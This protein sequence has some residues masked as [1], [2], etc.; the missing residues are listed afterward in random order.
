[1][2]PS[3]KP[4]EM[5]SIRRALDGPPCGIAPVFRWLSIINVRAPTQWPRHQHDGFEVIVVE[6]GRYNYLLNDRPAL[7]KAGVI[8]VVKPGDWHEDRYT[9]PLQFVGVGFDLGRELPG[10]SAFSIFA[11]SVRPEQ[12][13]LPGSCAELGPLLARLRQESARPDAVTPYVQDALLQQFFWSLIRLFPREVLSPWFLAAAGEQA[14]ITELIRQFGAHVTERL[15]LAQLAR[16]MQMSVSA[17][18]HKCQAGLRISPA[19][20]FMKYKAE[21]ARLLLRH[22]A[23]SI[24]EI[25]GYLGFQNPYHFSRVY[26]QWLGAPPS[27][28]R[29]AE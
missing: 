5:Y 12:Q 16:C 2:K 22:T 8:L 19:R 1:M 6:R 21:R 28:A 20:A 10:R 18:S 7:L 25:S 9:P 4:F 14:F 24:K 3:Q 13:C 11:E 17:L 23:M 29:L 15:S 27:R 26:K